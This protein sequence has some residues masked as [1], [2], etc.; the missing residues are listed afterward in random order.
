MDL[1]AVDYDLPPERIAQHPAE[2]R[3]AARLL[4]DEGPGQDPS[5][6]TVADLPDLVGPGD[7]L[8]INDTRVLHARLLMRKD[9]GG[10]V[11]VLLLEPADDG[12]DALVKPSRKVRPGTVL[13]PRDADAS[14]TVTV[15]DDFGEGRRRVRIDT[16]HDEMALLARHGTVPLPPYITT[17][18]D[19]ASRYQTVY[20][21]RPASV[22][23]PTA[24]L[25]LT[26][27][28]LDRCVQAGASIARVELVV[29][30]GTF[31]PITTD[32]VEDHVMHA[33][34]YSV[35]AETMAACERAERV[36]AIGTT[37]V[38]ALESA[39]ATGQL[40][41]RTDL[42][43]HGDYDWQVVDAMVTN[44]HVPRSSLLVMID[45]F[46][47]ARWRRFYTAAL[48]GGYRFLS[49]GDAM[50]LRRGRGDA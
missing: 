22:A 4:V 50:L 9:T 27:E 21:D 46:V 44:F 10:E 34:S 38:R 26:P 1:D 33:E 3:D 5:H 29:G 2:P 35:P 31:R 20:A 11:E 25:H 16:A 19:D 8:V 23:A 49:F 32:V 18:L 17:P 41:G 14:F 37:S 48:D 12:W 30:I 43:I 42:F 28:V 36:I 39:A 6:R 13:V 15:G 45:S 7:V 40:E 47:G 24:G